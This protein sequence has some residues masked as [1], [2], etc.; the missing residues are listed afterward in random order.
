MFIL[1]SL[2]LLLLSAEFLSLFVD[3]Y[4]FNFRMASHRRGKEAAAGPS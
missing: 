3:F 4:C 2:L 1:L